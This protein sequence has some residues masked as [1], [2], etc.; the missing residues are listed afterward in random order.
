M[1]ETRK[2]TVARVLHGVATRVADAQDVPMLGW[3]SADDFIRDFRL[4][5]AAAAIDALADA[6]GIAEAVYGMELTRDYDITSNDAEMIAAAVV[7][8]MKDQ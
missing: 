7:A 2:E 4:R 1:S 5:S 3:E 8:W 6:D